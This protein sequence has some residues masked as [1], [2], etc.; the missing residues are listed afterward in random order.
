MLP[1]QKPALN[2]LNY[3]MKTRILFTS[4]HSTIRPSGV[5]ASIALSILTAAALQAEETPT[6]QPPPEAAATTRAAETEADLAGT[7]EVTS[8]PEVAAA[9]QAQPSIYDKIWGYTQWYKNDENNIIQSFAFTGRFQA[10]YANI[11]ADQGNYEEWNI[12]RFRLGAK[13]T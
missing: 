6:L 7:A 3:P 12:R 13:A 4:L 10:D 8:P 9:A 5:T 1:T 2:R 11:D